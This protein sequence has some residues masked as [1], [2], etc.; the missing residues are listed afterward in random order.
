[1]KAENLMLKYKFLLASILVAAFLNSLQAQDGDGMP[2]EL[3]VT[4]DRAAQRGIGYHITGTIP[5]VLPD[6]DESFAVQAKMRVYWR[7][8]PAYRKCKLRVAFIPLRVL[9]RRNRDRLTL[10]ITTSTEVHPPDCNDGSLIDANFVTLVYSGKPTFAEFTLSVADGSNEERTFEDSPHLDKLIG[11]LALHLACPVRSIDSETAPAVSVL[12]ADTVPWP[13][14]FDDTKTSAELSALAKTPWAVAGLTRPGKPYP[15]MATFRAAS[16]HAALRPG[17][18]FWVKSIQVEFTP[19]EILLSSKYPAGSCEYKAVLEHEMLH[20][21]DLQI[22]FIRYLALVKAALRQGTL[23]TIERPV[24]VESV[25]EGLSRSKERIQSMLQPIY[26]S[27]EKAILADAD[28]RDTPEERLRSWKQCPNW[29]ASFAG[30][31]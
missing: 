4:L 5:L 9:G 13:L 18:C 17:F 1:V 12:P 29:Y 15:P 26:A 3:E 27:M 28:A 24:F 11:K 22:L 21:Q 10:T 7:I 14:V 30:V 16:Q 19:V 31:E 2:A 20:Y 23:P 25:T 6:G 8:S